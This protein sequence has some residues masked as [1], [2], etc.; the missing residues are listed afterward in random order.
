[1]S[2][3]PYRILEE[4]PAAGR[5]GV[6]VL[7]VDETIEA[8]L[9]RMLPESRLHVTRIPSG[10]ELTPATIATM[11]AELTRAAALLP[12]APFDVLAYGC[13]SGTTLIGAEAVA[14]RVRAGREARHVTD[15]LT[16]ALAAMAALGIRSVALVSPY[17]P[18]I[19]APIRAAFV[20]Q[21]IEVPAAISFG[22]RIEARVARI[23]PASI[24]EAA[25][26]ALETDGADAVFLSCTNLRTL[27]IIEPLERET[28]RP[29]LSS[30]QVLAWHMA[31]LSE[32]S[33]PQRLPG[34]LGGLLPACGS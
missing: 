6:I 10:A 33:P 23:D 18:E 31:R 14:R 22:E 27:D 29:V 7:Q 8:D 24:R 26:K 21:G 30:N 12:D 3:F 32:A 9:R 34:R 20:A 28:G 5:L 25:L 11:E 19:A 17:I 13:T 15:P 16:A 1:M 2:G 4:D